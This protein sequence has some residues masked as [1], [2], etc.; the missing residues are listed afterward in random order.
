MAYEL[1]GFLDEIPIEELNILSQIYLHLMRKVL[2]HLDISNKNHE[3]KFSCV[4]ATYLE[5]CL[6]YLPIVHQNA[7]VDR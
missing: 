7:Q 1:L 3:R 6:S 4:P 5:F 2:N